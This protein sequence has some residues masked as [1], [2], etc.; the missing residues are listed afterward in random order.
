MGKRGQTQTIMEYAAARGLL[1]ALGVL[2]RPAAVAAGRAL[3]R[4]AHMLGGGLRRTG[5]I[6]LRLA[7][8]DMDERERTR[9]LRGCY[10]SLGR[11]L[12]EFSQFPRATRASLRELID[13]DPVG[14]SHLRAAEAAGRG[15]I[16]L[17]GHIG[18]WEVLSFGW[19][20]LEYPL[21]FMVRP[22]DNPRI[23]ALV[24][25]MRTRFGNVAIDKKSAARRALK[26]LHQ[27]GALGI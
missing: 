22:I 21:N 18:G 1:G 15:V 9:I 14:L 4:L 26:A 7:F 20:A 11:T 6:N 12:G 19:S 3:G 27:G 2:P 25:R 23:E 17:T 24:E 13:Y 16:F 5:E 8:P 10:D